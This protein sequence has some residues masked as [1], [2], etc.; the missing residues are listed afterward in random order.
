MNKEE[1]LHKAQN[2][3][4]NDY[5]EMENQVMLKGNNI[6]LGISLL[7]CVIFMFV[8]MQLNLPYYDVYSVGTTIFA[9]QN[10]YFGIKTHHKSKIL[11]GIG[12]AI[13]TVCLVG[14][15]IYEVIG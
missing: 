5:D 12:W 11:L 8:K 6:A 15:Y 14:F 3:K 9:V 13:L 1:I 7:L 10:I 2:R 4:K